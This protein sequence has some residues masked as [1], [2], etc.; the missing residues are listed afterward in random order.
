MLFNK[1]AGR[2][3]IDNVTPKLI[4]DN[5][6]HIHTLCARYSEKQTEEKQTNVVILCKPFKINDGRT[7]EANTEEHYKFNSFA[8]AGTALIQTS[9]YK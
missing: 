6:K 4:H 3:K 1:R 5:K 8:K 2:E 7:P 9:P